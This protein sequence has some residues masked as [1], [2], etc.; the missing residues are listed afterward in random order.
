[1]KIDL[2]LNDKTI[3]LESYDDF[4][5]Y[6][7]RKCHIKYEDKELLTE[8]SV[9]SSWIMDLS[10]DPEDETCIMLVNSPRGQRRYRYEIV[11]IDED[12]FNRWLDSSSKGSFFNSYVRGR[13]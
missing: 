5:K 1:M 10:Y 6:N 7:G 13:Y 3:E 9:D 2:Y 12:T 11:G 4:K 8:D